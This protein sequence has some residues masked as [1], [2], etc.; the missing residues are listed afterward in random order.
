MPLTDDSNG[1]DSDLDDSDDDNADAGVSHGRGRESTK[2]ATESAEER[3]MRE[4]DDW[5]FGRFANFQL[6]PRGVRLCCGWCCAVGSDRTERVTS[7]IN[8]KRKHRVN[9]LVSLGL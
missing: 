9:V 6:F 8:V 1:N 4:R 3:W 7:D 5:L 2:K